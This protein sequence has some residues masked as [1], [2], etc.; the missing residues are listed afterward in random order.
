VDK[1]LWEAFQSEWN[2]M[3]DKARCNLKS[4]CPLIEDEV[5][6]W[7]DHRLSIAENEVGFLTEYIRQLRKVDP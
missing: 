6:V 1:K 2:D 5:L 4:D 7:I 3:L